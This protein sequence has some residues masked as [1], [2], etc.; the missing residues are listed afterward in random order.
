MLINSLLPLHYKNRILQHQLWDRWKNMPLCCF[1]LSFGVWTVF[2][3]YCE[4]SNFKQKISIEFINTKL[5]AHEMNLSRGGNWS[6]Q[7]HFPKTVSHW[8]FY[9][10]LLTELP[11]TIVTDNFF[12]QFVQTQK[13]YPT[14]FDKV[15]ILT[16]IL[17]IKLNFSNKLNSYR[18]YSLQNTSHLSVQV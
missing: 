17:L 4:K 11:R 14:F 1:F 9:Y 2:L 16:W 13:S 7:E 6:F 10:G 18:T 8:E 5:K 3:W 15:I 12:A